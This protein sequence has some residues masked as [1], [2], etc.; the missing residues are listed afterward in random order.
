MTKTQRT[1]TNFERLFFVKLDYLVNKETITVSSAS[2][3]DV[4][5]YAP[6][7]EKEAGNALLAL[8]RKNH[9]KEGDYELVTVV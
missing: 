1:P 3:E 2:I 7:I 8:W 4:K 6:N 9:N 5:R